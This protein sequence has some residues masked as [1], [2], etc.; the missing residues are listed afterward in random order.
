TFVIE[1]PASITNLT[2][3]ADL[4]GI[5][6]ARRAVA[7]GAHAATGLPI[8]I[9]TVEFSPFTSRLDVRTIQIR[10]PPGFPDDRFADVSRLYADYRLPSLLAGRN[11]LR[12][13][14]IEINHLY[15]VKNQQGESNYRKLPAADNKTETKSTAKYRFDQLHF[16]IG[17]VTIKDYSRAKPTERTYT[18]NLDRTYYDVTDSTDISRLILASLAGAIPLPDLKNL[19]DTATK[20]GQHLLDSLKQS[21][22]K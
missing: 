15:L 6:V 5:Q 1:D 9:A 4:N 12:Q 14:A 8:E 21:L 13:L 22:P 17:K 16:H 11:H 7:I 19:A 10:N 2:L 18:L 3:A 20:T